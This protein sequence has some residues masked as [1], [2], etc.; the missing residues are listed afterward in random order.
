MTKVCYSQYLALGLFLTAHCFASVHAQT[1]SEV[2]LQALPPEV[3]RQLQNVPV[4]DILSGKVRVK[5]SL[6]AMTEKDPDWVSPLA[7]TLHLRGTSGTALPSKEKLIAERKQAGK[8]QQTAKDESKALME[9][10]SKHFLDQLSKIP[11][12]PECHRDV[13]DFSAYPTP[14]GDSILQ[15]ILF[16]SA[17]QVPLDVDEAFGDKTIVVKYS[18][19]NPSS[20][21][22]FAQLEGIKCL[23][24]RIRISGRGVYRLEGIPALK[25][26]QSDS[27]GDGVLSDAIK[28]KVRRLQTGS[29]E[30]F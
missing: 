24:S 29:G 7:I 15:D 27:S 9:R 8:Q 1:L 2:E 25:N 6:P 20:W 12:L 11:P 21:M 28:A 26:Y 22:Q 17:E 3:A 13:K 23:P 14:N 4:K 18:A 10:A 16:V 5:S 19:E 30:G